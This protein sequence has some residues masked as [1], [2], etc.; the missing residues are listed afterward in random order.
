MSAAY[1]VRPLTDRTWLTPP[2]QR[3]RSRFDSAW[4]STLELL[5]GEVEKIGGR[6]LVIEIDVPERGIRNDGMLRADARPDDP[7]VVVAFETKKY[8]PLR[9]E[10]DAYSQLAYG[11]RATHPWQDNVRAVALTLEALRAVERHGAARKGEAYRGW[12]ARPALA[13]APV[14]SSS[15]AYDVFC[16]LLGRDGSLEY[17]PTDPR[18]IRAVKARA[19]PDQNGGDRELW[20]K[21]TEAAHALGCVW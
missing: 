4:G 7:A 18:T 13:S 14:M 10:S 8:G 1:R 16:D 6:D 11:S 21:A 3:R 9:Y 15:E 20:E 19:H 17:P 2:G 5:L 12:A